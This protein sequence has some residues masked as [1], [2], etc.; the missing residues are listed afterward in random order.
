[1]FISIWMKQDGHIKKNHKKLSAIS[2][3]LPL[4]AL[5]PWGNNHHSLQ[6]QP[7]AWIAP[8]CFVDPR[9]YIPI[10]FSD[11]KPSQLLKLSFVP[12]RLRNIQLGTSKKVTRLKQRT[13]LSC[14]TPPPKIFEGL[15]GPKATSES[16]WPKSKACKLTAPFLFSWRTRSNMLFCKMVLFPFF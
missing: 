11:I 5:C 6:S 1:M 2:N 16:G 3:V 12:F 13:C 8:T 4:I 9:F 14:K 10:P 15:F 7:K